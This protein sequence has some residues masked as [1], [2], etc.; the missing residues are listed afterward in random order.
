MIYYL[1]SGMGSFD[2]QNEWKG[3]GEIDFTNSQNLLETW[4]HWKRGMEYYLTAT[5]NNRTDEAQKVAIFMCMIGKDVQEIKDT[6]EFEIGKGGQEVITTEI[7]FGKFEVYCKPKKNLVVEW[8]SFL[9]RDQAAGESVDQYVTK[10]RTLSASC[11]WGELKD[12][13]I[14]SQVVSGISSIVVGEWLL[15]ESELKLNK[16]I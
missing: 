2:D 13:L 10:L 15:H 11:E 8:H 5:C 9:T 4:R 12:N 3:P 6:F 14:C 16:A 1:V 7:L